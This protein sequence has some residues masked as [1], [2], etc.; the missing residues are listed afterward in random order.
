MVL[1]Q[2][3]QARGGVLA[4]SR[5]P[6]DRLLERYASLESE[7]VAV[8]GSSAVSGFASPVVG[9]HYQQEEVSLSSHSEGHLPGVRNRLHLSHTQFAFQEGRQDQ[10]RDPADLGQTG[11]LPASDR[12]VGRPLFGIDPGDLPGATALPCPAAPEGTPPAERSHLFTSGPL[13]GRSAR[14]VRVVAFPHGG[15][16][17]ESNFR[18]STGFGDRVGRQPRRLGCA[19]WRVF[20]RRQLVSSGT[21]A[22]HQLP[23]TPGR[24]LCG[25]VLHQRL[26]SC[27]SPVEDGQC[28]G[29]AVHKPSRGHTLQGVSDHGKTVLGILPGVSD[30]GDGGVSPRERESG[31]GLALPLPSRF[32]C[33]EAGSGDFPPPAGEMGSLLSRTLCVPSRSAAFPVLQLEAG[34]SGCGVR[35]VQSGLESGEGVRLSPVFHDHQGDGP[36]LPTVGICSADNPVLEVSSLVSGSSGTFLGFSNPTPPN[37]PSPVEFGGDSPP[38]GGGRLPTAHSM[39]DYRQRWRLLG[40]SGHAELLLYRAWADST[41]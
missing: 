5:G 12:S 22:S 8:T 9:V 38:S 11:N 26:S 13:D 36:S 31:G 40:L 34:S 28:V 29:C 4:D 1:H 27:L 20:H 23:R 16:E 15:M 33:L 19:V 35:C 7:S 2:G 21:A 17:R 32:Q 6:L 41:S 10:A 37:S 39:A 3:S 18:L 30:L 25:P 14:G 24:L